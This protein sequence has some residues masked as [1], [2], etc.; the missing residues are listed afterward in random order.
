M[1]V[2]IHANLRAAVARSKTAAVAFR[3]SAEEGDG[4]WLVDGFY[5]DPYKVK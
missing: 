4:T 2:P 5:I 3:L 1:I